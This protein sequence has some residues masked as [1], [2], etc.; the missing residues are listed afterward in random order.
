MNKK[1]KK[2]MV[3]I[4]EFLRRYGRKKQKNWDPNDR[5]YDRRMEERIKHMDP[6]E[7]DRLMRGES[8]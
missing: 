2:T 7:L 8:E 1:K 4:G 5:T 6:E 3:E